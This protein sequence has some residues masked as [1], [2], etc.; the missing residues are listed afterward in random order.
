MTRVM[1]S[2]KRDKIRIK[3]N[4]YKTKIRFLRILEKEFLTSF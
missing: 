4:E 3:I 2:F 1:T